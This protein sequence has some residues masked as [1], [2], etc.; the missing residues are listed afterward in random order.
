VDIIAKY[1]KVDKD[2]IKEET[3]GGHIYSIP[4]LTKRSYKV[5]DLINKSGY[6]SSDL[7]IENFID[8]SIYKL[9]L[10]DVLKEYPN[11]EVYKKLKADFKE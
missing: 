3:Y 8:T 6:I 4:D 11:D 9:A 5:L 10:E 2:I 7:N 1:A